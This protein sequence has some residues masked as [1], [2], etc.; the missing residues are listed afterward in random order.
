MTENERIARLEA[1]V[2]AMR[3]AFMEADARLSKDLERIERETK[4]RQSLTEGGFLGLLG[5]LAHQWLK[6][7]GVIS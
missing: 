6:A 1:Q 4:K 2:T 7:T 3:A 5:F